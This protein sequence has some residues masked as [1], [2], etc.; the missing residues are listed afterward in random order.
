MRVEGILK[1]KGRS[2]ETATP[3]ADLRV[4]LHKLS[5]LGIGALVVTAD[6]VRVAGT[7]SERDVVRGLN[8]HGAGLLDLRAKDVM[9]RNV[10]TCSPDD[11]LQHVMGVM[12]RTR[13]RH[14]PVVDENGLCGIVSVGDVVKHRL[15]EMELETNVLR[16]AHI[17]R[18]GTVDLRT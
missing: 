14:I 3:N 7:I 1:A 10:P 6:G 9:T 18:H 4:V 13:H 11:L 15:E 2:V 12:T 8:K 5:A 17:A 16:D